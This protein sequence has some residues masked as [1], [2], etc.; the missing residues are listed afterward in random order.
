MVAW[1]SETGLSTLT[2]TTT[3]A[4]TSRCENMKTNSRMNTVYGTPER[5]GNLRHSRFIRNIR[6]VTGRP[7]EFGATLRYTLFQCPSDQRFL[8]VIAQRY[9]RNTVA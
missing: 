8:V 5:V 3:M 2:V 9:Y 4:M 7:R 6:R 1:M